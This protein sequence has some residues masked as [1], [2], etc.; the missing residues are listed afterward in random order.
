MLAVIKSDF[1]HISLNR[2]SK[3]L[4]ISGAPFPLETVLNKSRTEGQGR[5]FKL[6]LKCA[7]SNSK[8]SVK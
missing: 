4:L 5:A 8:L 6:C 1:V 2:E 3:Q 7:N